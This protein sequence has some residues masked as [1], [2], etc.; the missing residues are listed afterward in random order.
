MKQIATKLDVEYE[1]PRENASGRKNEMEVKTN[2][3]MT[4]LRACGSSS[5]AFLL[6]MNCK[7]LEHENNS[8]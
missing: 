7:R 5:K 8:L 2:G 3:K 4:L 6:H 1:K